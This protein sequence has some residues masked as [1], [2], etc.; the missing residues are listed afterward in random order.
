[1][2]PT[3]SSFDQAFVKAYSRRQASRPSEQANGSS[4]E[5]V[6]VHQHY[7]DSASVW[8]DGEERNIQLRVDAAHRSR[9]RAND[10]T[11]Y[12]RSNSKRTANESYTSIQV[13]QGLAQPLAS[14][15]SELILPA[16]LIDRP[17]AEAN[18]KAST[19]AGSRNEL[20]ADQTAAAVRAAAQKAAAEK[21]AAERVAELKRTAEKIAAEKIAAERLA[22]QKQAAEKRLATK[23]AVETRNAKLLA[24]E[25]QQ[26][27][28]IAAERLEA[29]RLAAIQASELASVSVRPSQGFAAKWEI[30][31]LDIPSAVSEL[32]FEGDMFQQLAEQL[33]AAVKTG[34]RRLLVTSVRRS[35]GRTT[36][37]IG[38]SIAAAA[39]GIRVALVDGDARQ[40][41]LADDLRLEVDS[42][43]TATTKGSLGPEDIAI[44]AKQ[45]G[46]TLV[47]LLPSEKPNLVEMRQLLRD[48]EG[49]FELVI[50]DGGASDCEIT[51]GCFPMYDS[52]MI[53]CDKSRMALA[54]INRLTQDIRRCGVRGV[55]VIENFSS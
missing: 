21:V 5:P 9:G 3:M 10:E 36:V 31:A 26:A 52:A 46:V 11:S 27:D 1:M 18:V 4:L 2:K 7:A 25:R 39:A 19:T 23:L 16:T 53:V 8:L 34:L 15:S 51:T 50:V 30:D 40:P 47:P 41:S 13:L 42:G 48:L 49:C 17:V 29:E 22:A 45:D 12:T 55:G 33:S 6:L 14:V 37:A 20:A 44:Y 28:R 38:L 54:D 32:F 35:E 24:A 43:W